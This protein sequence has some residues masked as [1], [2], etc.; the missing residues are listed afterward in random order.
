[1]G[2]AI[3]AAVGGSLISGFFSS[4]SASKQAKEQKKQAEMQARTAIWQQ[5][6]ARKN[7]LEDRRYKEQA[8]GN[9]R[10]FYAGKQPVMAPQ[11]TDPNTVVLKDPITGK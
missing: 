7:Q 8:I 10:Q 2:V 9:Y 11:L 5:Q 3:A 1:M 6:Y 4:R